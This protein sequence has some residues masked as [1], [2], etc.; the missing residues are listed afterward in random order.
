M[1][2]SGN[3]PQVKLPPSFTTEAYARDNL[4][5]VEFVCSAL[6]R[7]IDNIKKE[8]SREANKNN[9]RDFDIAEM[10]STLKYL[11]RA[12]ENKPEYDDISRIF[13]PD[14][15]HRMN[16]VITYGDERVFV[17]HEPY[18]NNTTYSIDGKIF[19]V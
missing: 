17:S 15:V 19:H 4:K 9:Q 7:N 2:L 11:Y 3:L 1:K 10:Q 12:I 18:S 6:S 5:H 8:Q 14:N 16:D 13:N